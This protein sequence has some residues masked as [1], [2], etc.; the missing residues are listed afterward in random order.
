M[1][2]DIPV[3]ERTLTVTDGEGGLDSRGIEAQ[4]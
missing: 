2:G 3:Q 4:A 1:A